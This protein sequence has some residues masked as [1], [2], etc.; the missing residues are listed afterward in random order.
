MPHEE[1]PV[2]RREFT[3]SL[4][5]P[6]PREFAWAFW[7]EV[8]NWAAVDSAVESVGLDG[9]FE[10]G[11]RGETKPRGHAAVAWRLAEVEEGRG[12]T[13]EMELPG[14]VL[15]FAW[16]F[17]ESGAGG[18]KITQRVTLEGERA[19]DYAGGMEGLGRGVPEGMR[20]LAEAIAAARGGAR[21]GPPASP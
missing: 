3:H 8:G 9:P 13:I 17:E 4:E 16:T 6:A 18:T 5:C 14:A 7:S 10:A 11:A 2:V 19:G 21:T 1:G 15:R 20:R 12:A